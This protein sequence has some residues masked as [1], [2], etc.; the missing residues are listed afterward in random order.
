MKSLKKM[1]EMEMHIN[2][3]SIRIAYGYTIIF[4]AVW[5]FYDWI[6]ND[7]RGLPFFLFITQN[8]VLLGVSSFLKWKMNKDEK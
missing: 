6:Q 7:V 3:K 4:L 1:D 8:L 5:V 2:L